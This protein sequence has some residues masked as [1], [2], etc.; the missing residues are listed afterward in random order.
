[1]LIPDTSNICR[2]TSALI[3]TN[4]VELVVEN[5]FL[6]SALKSITGFGISAG[7]GTSTKYEQVLIPDIDDTCLR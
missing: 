2:N 5:T 4:T 6:V 3:G 7:I 1:M